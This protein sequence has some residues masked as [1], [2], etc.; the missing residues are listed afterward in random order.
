MLPST[1]RVL[2]V[3]AGV[4]RRHEYFTDENNVRTLL[5]VSKNTMSIRNAG[6]GDGDNV[7]G[8]H[9]DSLLDD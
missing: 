9:I 4:T 2:D 6:F 5:G 7:L 8:N 1:Y 3:R